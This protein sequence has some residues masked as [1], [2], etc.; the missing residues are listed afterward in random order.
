MKHFFANTLFAMLFGMALTMSAFS[1]YQAEKGRKKI[2]HL[3]KG[4]DLQ[5]W[6]MDVPEMDKNPKMTSP[7]IVKDSLLVSLGNPKGHLITD[8]VY[9]N[10][11]LEVEY[12]FPA[13]PGNCGVLIHASTPR[14]LYDMF[15]KSLEVQMQYLDAG[16]FW[17]IGEDI[18]VPNMEDRRG[19][20]DKWGSTEGKN[21]RI[22][23][24]TDGSEKPA[25]EWN[26]MVVECRNRSVKVWVNGELVN[27]GTNCTARK[28]QIALQAEGAEVEF[29]KVDSVY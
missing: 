26:Q 28:G 18:T 1:T 25:I 6:H 23:N 10:Y 12:R 11:R 21:R 29:R 20:K 2:I 27:A 8:K 13:S 7:F 4:K 15:P 3:F 17:C 16:D 14:V 22:R 5:G 19:P 24:L 9:Q